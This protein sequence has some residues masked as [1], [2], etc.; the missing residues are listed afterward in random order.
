MA[1]SRSRGRPALAWEAMLAGLLL[2]CFVLG[3]LLSPP[4]IG[5]ANIGNLLA[6]LS[7]TGLMALGLTL[8]IVAGEID[9]SIAS[10]L[11]FASALLGVLWQAG[12]PF[13]LCIGL[14]LAAGALAGGL[15]GLL[16]T[17]LGL[18]SLAVT[19]GTMALFRGGAYILLGD[20]A[21][22]DFPAAY[23]DFGISNI[24]ASF[25]PRTFLV[26]LPLAVV[27]VVVLQASAFGRA[28]YAMGSNETAARFSGLNP[29][30]A[31][32]ALF[33][34]SGLLSALAGVIYTLRFSSA[35]GDNGTGFELGVVAAVL[36]GGVSIFGG[37]GTLVG[38]LL[39]L[40]IVGV[41]NNALT[42]Y[43]VSNEILTIVTGLLLLSSVL[44][45]N[46]AETWRNARQSRRRLAGWNP[47]I[48]P[49]R[50][51]KT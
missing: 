8:L 6:N 42:L 32:T 11:G 47:R 9:L 36:F 31:K 45:P 5:T 49:P 20:A 1:E 16:V 30:R 21:V 25:L 37:K 51:E 46:L 2:V 23:T 35:R 17:R 4:F 26:L 13:P 41:L 50:R 12:L 18:P 28:L 48:Q 29:A 38:V 24:G 14:T 10:I 43:D 19:I 3:G 44:V 7:E 34:V 33:F 39:S 27:F 15:N 22:A 40:L